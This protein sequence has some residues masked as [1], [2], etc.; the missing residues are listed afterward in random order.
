MGATFPLGG[1]SDRDPA[2]HYPCFDALSSPQLPIDRP[3]R[4]LRPGRPLHRPG[5]LALFA[6]LRQHGAFHFINSAPASDVVG[7]FVSAGLA[8]DIA[9]SAPGTAGWGGKSLRIYTFSPGRSPLSGLLFHSE[10]LEAVIRPV[11]ASTIMGNASIASNFGATAFRTATT[12]SIAASPNDMT[13]VSP[14]PNVNLSTV[15]DPRRVPITSTTLHAASRAVEISSDSAGD[16]QSWV[17]LRFPLD[18]RCEETGDG[19]AHTRS[20]RLVASPTGRSPCRGA[21]YPRHLR[22]RKDWPTPS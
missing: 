18:Q 12:R 4:V 5:H 14:L 1:G 19:T 6:L 17:L 15:N 22:Y 9:S 7:A 16:R 10:L 2:R 11:S 8:H 21:A 20:R 3:R 13:S